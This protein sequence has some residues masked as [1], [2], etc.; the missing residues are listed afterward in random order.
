M[1]VEGEGLGRLRDH[2]S[3]SLHL[4]SAGFWLHLK[5]MPIAEVL[6]S[7]RLALATRVIAT[8]AEVRQGAVLSILHALDWPVFDLTR[9]RPSYEIDGDTVDFAL[10]NA[11]GELSVVIIVDAPPKLDVDSVDPRAY[12][13]SSAR[14]MVVHTNGIVWRF[15]LSQLPMREMARTEYRTRLGHAEEVQIFQ[16]LLSP[17]SVQNGTART[18]LAGM[19]SGQTPPDES[20]VTAWDTLFNGEFRR[21]LSSTVQDATGLPPTAEQLDAFFR[22][23]SLAA[24]VKDTLEPS[25]ATLHSFLPPVTRLE[26]NVSV[27]APRLVNP[28]ARAGL[29]LSASCW[30]RIHEVRRPARSA[31]MVVVEVLRDMERRSP[32]LLERCAQ[33]PANVGTPRRYLGRNPTDLYPERPDLGND[34][35]KSTELVP[36]WFLMTN[37]NNDVKRRILAFVAEQAGM[38]V[39]DTLDYSLGDET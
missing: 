19:L 37:F 4:A 33:H 39:G 16:N 1:V 20:L 12:A 3:G 2:Y 25:P 32:G 26:E 21:L 10:L 6:Q 9:V 38:Q 28:P 15:M 8:K 29:D 13:T 27:P 18:H 31:K 5:S 11:A 34:P 14:P 24:P 22:S 36:G 23:W 35:G 30:W 17:A 7:V